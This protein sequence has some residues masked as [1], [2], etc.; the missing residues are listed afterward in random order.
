MAS[1]VRGVAEEDFEKDCAAVRAPTLV[2]TGEEQLDRVVPVCSTR[3]YVSLIPRAEYAMLT[4]TGHMG[5]LT[6]PARFAQVVTGF[7]HASHN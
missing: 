7:V 4:G 1:R 6:Q 3:A 2:I 5:L